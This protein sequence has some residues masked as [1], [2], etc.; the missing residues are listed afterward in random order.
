MTHRTRLKLAS[1]SFAILWTLWMAWIL[2]PLLPAQLGMLA[3]SGALS[4]FVWYWLYGAWYRWY[5]VRGVFP[6]KHT[7]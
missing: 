5:F 6:H 7:S 2:S 4:G 1:F 3:V